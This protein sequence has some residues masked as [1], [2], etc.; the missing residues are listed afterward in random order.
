MQAL[1]IVDAQNEFSSSGLRPVPNHS[2]ALRRIQVHV[3]QARADKRPIA[4]VQH[5]NRPNESRAF[6][7]GTW[8]AELTPGMGPQ[9]TFGPEKLFVKDV[10]GAFTAT[11]LGEWLHAVGATEVLI[12]G[13]YAHMCLSTA[14]REALIRGFEVFLD[15]EA[16]GARDLEDSVLGR[17]TADEVRRS[18]L[19]HLTN[20]GAKIVVTK[21]EPRRDFARAV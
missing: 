1:L 19:L 18:T 21:E 14:A 12:A 2:S 4:W 6:V 10:Y 15:P 20:M 9:A 5:H 8:G 3:E 13:F 7:P 16:T 17:Q 11:G